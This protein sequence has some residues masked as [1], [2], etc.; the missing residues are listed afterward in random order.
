M[1]RIYLIRHGKPSST[2][3]ENADPDPGLDPAGQD[4]ARRVAETLLA[5]PEGQRP[6][7]VISSP[8]RRCRETAMPTAQ[9]LGV[10]IEIDPLVGEIPTPTALSSAER[11]PWLRTAFAGRWSEIKGDLDY[12]DWRRAV[13]RAVGSRDNAAIFSHYVAI[14]A[15]ISHLEGLDEVLAFR[16]D[17][18]SISV[19]ELNDARLT[20]VERGPEA[21]TGVL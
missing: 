2:W 7:K 12:E 21:V 14:N 3:G 4:Q 13:A 18:A 17:H 20:L 19:F 11:G 8:L 1:G 5:L 16:P 6:A 9:A 15:V 10:E